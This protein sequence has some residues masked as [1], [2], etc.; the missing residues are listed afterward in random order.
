MVPIYLTYEYIT[1][2]DFTTLKNKHQVR[3]RKPAIRNVLWFLKFIKLHF[4]LE[5]VS[6]ILYFPLAIM[7]LLE[8]DDSTRKFMV[9]K[10]IT[11]NIRENQEFINE[12]ERMVG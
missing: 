7:E 8:N 3:S 4:S 6:C 5:S 12:L 10:R 2:R 11:E 9:H 1:W